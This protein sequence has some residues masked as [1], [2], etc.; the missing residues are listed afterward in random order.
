MHDSVSRL[1]G[2]KPLPESDIQTVP[3]LFKELGID[4]LKDSCESIY[5]H[6]SNQNPRSL[7]NHKLEFLT[8]QRTMITPVPIKVETESTIGVDDVDKGDRATYNTGGSDDDG[9]GY[10][11]SDVKEVESATEFHSHANENI[12]EFGSFNID[13][14]AGIEHHNNYLGDDSPQN[15]PNKSENR[16]AKRRKVAYTDDNVKNP[17]D[18]CNKEFDNLPSLEKHRKSVHSSRNSKCDICKEVFTKYIDLKSHMKTSHPP[19][20]AEK[21]QKRFK[22]NRNNLKRNLGKKENVCHI[23]VKGQYGYHFPMF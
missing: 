10:F 23:S 8:N 15:G 5:E 20:K 13:I 12:D 9:D 14:L 18:Q 16:T 6:V 11:D 19:Y 21:T 17:C 22:R 1:I 7:T 4:F 2:G 3:S